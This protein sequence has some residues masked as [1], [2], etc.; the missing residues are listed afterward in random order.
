MKKRLLLILPILALGLLNMPAIADDPSPAV[1]ASHA[2]SYATAATQKNGVVLLR[3]ENTTD[4]DAIITSASA[5]VSETVELHTHIMDGGKMMMREV[6]SYNVPANGS[7]ELNPHGHHIMLMGLK[8][9]LE[10]GETFPLTL[11]LEN[12]E[13]LETLVTVIKPGESL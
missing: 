1:E 3:V 13:T 9:P 6:E 10:L 2:Y 8:A 4:Q 12:G 5:D 11:T 7:L